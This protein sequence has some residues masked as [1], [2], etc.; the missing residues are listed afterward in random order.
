MDLT[1]WLLAEHDDTAA[2]LRGQV[3]DLVPAGRRTERPGGGSP[4]LWN[5]FHL[6]RHAA[7][8]LDVLEPGAAPPAPDW[9]P[10]L[11]G[12]G[13]GTAAA[14]GLEEA[15][16]SWADDLPAVSVDAYL[17]QVLDRTRVFLAGP[18]LDFDAVPDVAVSLAR[19]G[20]GEDDVP[21]LRRM[22]T[23]KPAAWL[24]RWPLTGHIG[25]HVGEMLAT[26]NRMGLSP[27]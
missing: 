12:P 24:I 14:A 23:G 1:Q 22:W 18:G 13:A 15:P 21:W 16:A 19:A 25:N 7:L 3:L 5:A 11:A 9:L 17:S 20:I 4:I 27:F 2:R 8:A 26:R 10:R 6:A